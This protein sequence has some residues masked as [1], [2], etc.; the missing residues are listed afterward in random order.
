MEKP[1]HYRRIVIAT[2][3]S[4]H[5]T[6]AVQFLAALPWANAPSAWIVGV[7][8]GAV[9]SGPGPGAVEDAR[10]YL[11]MTHQEERTR[12]ERGIAEA[13]SILR[14]AF[15]QGAVVEETVRAGEPA[16]EVM[17]L[18][19]EVEADLIVAGARGHGVVRGVLLGSVSEGLVTEARC[20]VLIVRET[21]P[22]LDRV[23]VAA[24]TPEDGAR[25]AGALLALPLPPG[26]RVITTSVVGDAPDTAQATIDDMATRAQAAGY[27]AETLIL[28]GDPGDALLAAVAAQDVCLIAVGARQRGGLAG[29]LGLGSVSR[30]LV[31]RTE[32]AVLVVR[33][34]PDASERS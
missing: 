16:A 28:T 21:L 5:A 33:P 2:D 25:I 19:G 8:G 26:T 27:E 14:P 18:A 31:R 7:V 12:A 29:R 24:A 32:R 30:Q 4:P 34:A 3:G 23:M 9:P 1:T 13:V 6:A 10:R 11:E 22:A 20:P 17:A 15:G